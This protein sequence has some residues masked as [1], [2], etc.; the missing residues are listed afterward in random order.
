MASDLKRRNRLTDR[1][2][3]KLKITLDG[4]QLKLTIGLQIRVYFF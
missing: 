3:I 2:I 1:Q 4:F